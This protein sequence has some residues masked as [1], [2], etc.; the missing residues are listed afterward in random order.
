M[1]L[2]EAWAVGLPVIVTDVGGITQICTD[3]ENALVIPPEDPFQL[4]QAMQFL[5]EHPDIREK[6]G[7]EGNRIARSLYSWDRIGDE[8]LSAYQKVI[9]NITH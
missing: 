9:Q 5:M 2:L 8:Y 1:T 3:R 4:C 6:L 7:L